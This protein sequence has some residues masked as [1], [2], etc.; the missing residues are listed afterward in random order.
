VE[1]AAVTE[2]DAE[3]SPPPE[4]KA[5]GKVRF[6]DA[7]LVEVHEDAPNDHEGYTGSEMM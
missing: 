2:P 7:N 4:G 1:P 5:P 6:K 3:I